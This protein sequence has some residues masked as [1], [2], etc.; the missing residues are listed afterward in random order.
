MR[1]AGFGEA[2]ERN[3]SF[4][5][6][7]RSGAASGSKGE[8]RSVAGES[9]SAMPAA[10]PAR[11]RSVCRSSTAASL[12][13]H[14]LG[15]MWAFR[16]ASGR[17]NQFSSALY[18]PYLPTTVPIRSAGWR[19]LWRRCSRPMRVFASRESAAPTLIVRRIKDVDCG[20]IGAVH[21]ASLAHC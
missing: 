17:F 8:M 4:S 2:E 14:R 15:T 12:C 13:T 5:S 18:D 10:K 21:S 6:A 3:P 7:A 19:G 20:D 11:S 9:S 1:G 16:Q